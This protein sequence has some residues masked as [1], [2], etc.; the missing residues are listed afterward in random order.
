MA[1]NAAR[2]PG[3]YAD[4]NGLYLL[5]DPSGAKRWILRTV[6]RGDRTDLGLGGLSLVSLA[7]ARETA[8]AWRKIA[9]KGGDPRAERRAQEALDASHKMTFGQCA[10]AYVEAHKA[11]WKNEK[12]VDQWTNTLETYCGP[13]MGAL[14]VQAVDTGLVLQVLEPIWQTKN[15]TASRLRGRIEKTLDWATVRGYRAG[16]NPARWRGHLDK[17]L[18]TISRKRRIQHHPALPFA[19]VGEF[20][21]LLR[22]QEGVAALALEYTVLTAARTSETIGATWPEFDLK[23]GV[24]TVPAARMKG[25]REH[26]VPLSPRALEIL[27]ALDE[28]RQDGT[29]VFPGRAAGQPQS[30]MAMLKLLGRMGR[31]DLTVHGFRSTFR[32]WTA[33]RTSYPRDVCEMALAH[34]V[35]DQVEAAYRR[36]DLFDKRR[37]LMNEWARYCGT[38]AKVGDVVPMRAKK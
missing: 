22:A 31:T 37:R 10:T 32:D 34:S 2:R 5:V 1:V 20:M 25:H 17:L 24:W 33:E 15:E 30:N 28:T 23:A 6:V 8:A 3:R 14:P 19:E 35:S 18:P 13:V 12:H 26:R 29:Y 9:R 38:A 16:E 11:S 4:G 36:G 21:E 27:K 7:E